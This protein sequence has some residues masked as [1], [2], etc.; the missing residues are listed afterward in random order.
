MLLL[1]LASTASWAET[2]Y[3]IDTLRV[4]VRQEPGRDTP[5][6]GVV[7]TGM[8]LEA[9]ERQ[10]GFVKIRDN[11]GLVGWIKDDYLSTEKPAQLL[12][13]E[14]AG[15]LEQLDG[16][17]SEA[18]EALEAAR[19]EKESALEELARVQRELEESDSRPAPTA[20]PHV[21]AQPTASTTG[22]EHPRFQLSTDTL[23]YWIGGIL[24]IALLGFVSGIS[25]YKNHVSRK[26]GGLRI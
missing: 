21:A 1:T 6:L 18:L 9:L 26:L 12:R 23:P 24:F 2:V 25:W 4:N 17:L 11:D 13:Q 15:R 3:V 20:A 7:V 14:E 19:L 16:E 5:P 22:D 8:A 10:E